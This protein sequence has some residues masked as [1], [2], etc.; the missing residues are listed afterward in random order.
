MG[1]LQLEVWTAVVCLIVLL[2]I[3]VPRITIAYLEAQTGYA[4]MALTAI[5]V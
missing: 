2:E 1:A 5:L 3:F 4:P